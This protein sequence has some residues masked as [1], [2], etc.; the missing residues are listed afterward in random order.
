MPIG[1]Q[2]K[3]RI[4]HSLIQWTTRQSSTITASRD[5][6]VSWDSKMGPQVNIGDDANPDDRTM[7]VLNVAII[8]TFNYSG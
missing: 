1:D 4:Q 7:T 3:G 8:I 6:H 5:R 2:N